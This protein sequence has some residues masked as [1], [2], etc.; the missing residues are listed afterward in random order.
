MACRVCELPPPEEVP[1]EARPFA[2]GPRIWPY[3][4]FDPGYPTYVPAGVLEQF[5]AEV[6]ANIRRLRGLAGEILG[7]G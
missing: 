7:G 5:A 4:Q 1:P 2:T 3:G 6:E